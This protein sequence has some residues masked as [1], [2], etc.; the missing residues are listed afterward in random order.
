MEEVDKIKKS[1]IESVH[2]LNSDNGT[3]ASFSQDYAGRQIY[4][5]LQNAEDQAINTDG[6]VKIELSGNILT[7]SNTGEPFSAKGIISILYVC[8]SPKEHISNKTIGYKGIGFRS[9]LNWSDE[10]T[11]SSNGLELEFS[12]NQA[13]DTFSDILRQVE[14]KEE[15][16]KNYKNITNSKVPILVCPKITSVYQKSDSFD[17][18][19][20]FKCYDDV[21]EDVKKQI[22]ELQPEVLLFLKKLKTIDLVIDGVK[23]QFTRESNQENTRKR[24]TVKYSDTNITETKEYIFFTE[25]GEID[26]KYYE[27]SIGYDRENKTS[28]EVLYSY[29]RTNVQIS[30]PAFI[31]ATFE[32]TSNRN[33][34]LEKDSYNNQ[35]TEKLV[36]KLVKTAVEIAGIDSQENIAT[37]EP[38]KILLTNSIDNSLERYNFTNLIKNKIQS[39]SLFPTIKNTFIS[40][41]DNPFYSEYKFDKILFKDTFS[42]LLKHCEDPIIRNYILREA[43]LSFYSESDFRNKLNLDIVEGRYTREEKCEL[44]LLIL[45]NPDISGEGITLLEDM[46]GNIISSDENV[47]V[48]PSAREKFASPAW[49]WLKVKFLN[50]EMQKII[51]KGIEQDSIDKTFRSFK[52]VRYRFNTLIGK[53]ISDLNKN[54]TVENVRSVVTWLFHFYCTP[55]SETEETSERDLGTTKVPVIC[56]N[57]LI[58]FANNA[59]FG[60]EYENELGEKL[61]SS[62]DQEHFLAY[63]MFDTHDKQKVIKFFEW[64]GVS[65]FPRIIEYSVEIND[66]DQYSEFNFSA[67]GRTCIGEYARADFHSKNIQV[68]KVSFFESFKEIVQNVE[69]YEIISWF[70]LDS[71]VQQCLNSL[72]EVKNYST[73]TYKNPQQWKTRSFSN[74]F[75]VSFARFYLSTKPWIKVKGV[76]FDAEHCCLEDIKLEQIIIS[77]KIDMQ[78]IKKYYP[79]ASKAE[80]V[81]LLTK[82]GVSESFTDLKTN[83]KYELLLRLPEIDKDFKYAKS[84]YSKMKGSADKV[85]SEKG[86]N[87][88]KFITEGKVLVSMDGINKYVSVKEAKYTPNK[89]YSEKILKKFPMFVYDYRQGKVSDLFGIELLG[90]IKPVISEEQINLIINKHFISNFNEFKVYVLASRLILNESD[91]D[92]RKLNRLNIILVNSVKVDFPINGINT[93]VKLDDFQTVYLNA[94]EDQRTDIAYIKIPD[95]CYTYTDIKSNPYFADAVAEIVTTVLDL[96]NDLVFFSS[97]FSSSHERR[98]NILV[99]TK[100]EGV[101]ECI[102]TAEEKL[103]IVPDA[104]K[105]FWLSIANAKNIHFSDEPNVEDIIDALKIDKEWETK[106]DYSHLTKRENIQ[107]LISLFK[108]LEIDIEDYNKQTADKIYLVE[109]YQNSFERLKQDVQEQYFIFLFKKYKDTT[110][111]RQ[112][113]NDRQNYLNYRAEFGNSVKESVED[114]FY[115]AFGVSCLDLKSIYD[116]TVDSIIIE[117]QKKNSTVYLELIKQY[118][119]ETVDLYL[120]FDCLDD[121]KFQDN[122]LPSVD[123]SS[124]NSLKNIVN[125]AKMLAE[126][127]KFE[128]KI[129]IKNLDDVQSSSRNMHGHTFGSGKKTDKLNHEKET[130]GLAG[131]IAVYKILKE[132]YSTVDW[133]SENAVK[134]GLLHSGDDSLGYDMTYINNQKEKI[135]VEVKAT[136]GKNIEFE[137]SNKEFSEALKNSDHYEVFFV[138]VNNNDGPRILNLGKLFKFENENESPFNNSKFTVLYDKYIIK[139][140]EK[141]DGRCEYDAHSNI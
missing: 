138:F 74:D 87:Y 96:N 15:Y 86:P 33:E 93:S 134:Y 43:R 124:N 120:L 42:T 20:K 136:T 24:L 76:L 13:K 126:N 32:L 62:Y 82:I 21:I 52:L 12:Q 9:V 35:L 2:R 83:I 39:E 112:Y 23:K 73:M 131:E 63:E 64:L 50:E 125:E 117:K 128:S 56:R 67:T 5:L 10:I 133:V 135:M 1:Y 16:E 68:L 90:D 104:K 107:N 92:A 22:N 81:G 26:N 4:E 106:F 119:P 49:S 122:N 118:P 25:E 132:I 14:N 72:Y 28:G 36:S 69:F 101:L 99:N 57:N 58:D 97:L 18:V 103:N 40:L 60:K 88:E 140:Q 141:T 27:I 7:V 89:L 41:S 30:F 108:T 95:N 71:N 94:S 84:I 59:Y 48:H 34:L 98:K 3:A 44:I 53:I 55:K 75:L 105:D 61:I 115:D 100:G 31:H 110:N 102:K 127:P 109:F 45:D 116:Q 65:L 80:V 85:L 113:E 38:I 29:F 11:I 54:K 37:Y 129:E 130:I 17:T 70:L 79:S 111:I 46:Q 51:L 66:R 77:P 8:N 78:E 139:A 47:Y 91:N 121:L 114:I 123:E 19:I 137:L 6:Y